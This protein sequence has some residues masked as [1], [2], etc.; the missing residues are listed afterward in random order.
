MTPILWTLALLLGVPLD[1]TPPKPNPIAPSL[2]LLTPEEEKELDQVVDRFIQF[3]TGKLKGKEGKEAVS[4]FQKLGP[5]A[6]PA[7]IRGVNR[8]ARIEYSCPAVTIAKKLST[9]L[10][11]SKD[12]E[13]LE[14]ARENIGVGITQSRHMKVLQQLRVECMLRKNALAR[15]PATVRTVPPPAD[16][17]TLTTSQLLTE[18]LNL[19]RGPRRDSVLKEFDSRRVKDLVPDLGAVAA[20]DANG[21]TQQKARELLDRSLARL[22]ADELRARL[23]DDQVEV[24]AA[25]A[26]V[27]GQKGLH[28]EQE[29]IDLLED[30]NT[31]LRQAARRAL[32]R[33]N[34]RT[35][36]GPERQANADERAAAV[37]RWRDWL[38]RQN[39][40]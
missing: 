27:V 22:P 2:R 11:A 34:P 36:F 14:F 21:A 29:L 3:D 30:D 17:R 15:M 12:P 9:L 39:D 26:R 5:D 32:V 23:Q 7:L 19:S 4:E 31:D 35:D 24:R 16:L 40:Q 25:A 6:I 28:F 37:K 20:N 8:A 38:A 13:L 1:D 10:R 18:A 33:L